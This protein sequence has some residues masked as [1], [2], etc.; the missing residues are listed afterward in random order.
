MSD[1]LGSLCTAFAFTN[2]AWHGTKMR[3]FNAR[4]GHRPLTGTLYVPQLSS[5][6]NVLEVMRHKVKQLASFY[7]TYALQ[8]VALPAITV[9]SATNLQNVPDASVDYVFTDPPFARNIFY[10]DCNLIW[11]SARRPDADEERSRR[12]PLPCSQT[13][14]ARPLAITGA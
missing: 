3:R 9:G 11:E 8:E 5:E 1:Q 10:A 12:Q 13:R 6:A 2:T 14:A 4:G 7:R